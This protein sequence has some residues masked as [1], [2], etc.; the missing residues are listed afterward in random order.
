[1]SYKHNLILSSQLSE[2]SIL[3]FPSCHWRGNR[4]C[5]KLGDLLTITWQLMDV[6]V[7]GFILYC[8]LGSLPLAADKAADSERASMSSWSS[9]PSTYCSLLL[10]YLKKTAD[11]DEKGNGMLSPCLLIHELIQGCH[12]THF[13]MNCLS[14][15][16]VHST[17]VENQLCEKHCAAR[18]WGEWSIYCHPWKGPSIRKIIVWD[19]K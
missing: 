9:S 17:L 11:H 1:M 2:R 12:W 13:W 16:S 6:L 18:V 4:G 10:P 19:G 3:C 15:P 8:W 7:L 5:R 14:Y